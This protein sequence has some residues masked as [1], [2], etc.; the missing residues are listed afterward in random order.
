VS[1]NEGDH[2]DNPLVQVLAANEPYLAL[3]R[4]V[5][6]AARKHFGR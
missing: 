4:E 6:A 3:C 5:D 2:K 1:Y